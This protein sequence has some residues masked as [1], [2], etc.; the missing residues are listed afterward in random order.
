[1]G[2]WA[3]ILNI[4]YGWDIDAHKASMAMSLLK[5]VREA[6]APQ[7]DNRVD[8]AGYLDMADRAAARLYKTD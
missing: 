6:H 4:L 8:S 5:H 1:M 3:A 7:R 2:R